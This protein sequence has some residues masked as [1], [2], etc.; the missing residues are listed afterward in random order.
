MSNKVY[1][2]GEIAN[3][4]GVKTS[5]LRFWENEFSQVRPKRTEKGQRYYSAKDLEILTQI[6]ELL[7][8]QGMTINGVQKAL[9]GI[10]TNEKANTSEKKQIHQYQLNFASLTIEKPK[11]QTE[12]TNY[13]A[14][15]DYQLKY[16]QLLLDLQNLQDDHKK[17]K[18]DFDKQNKYITEQETIIN[19]LENKNKELEN[20][21]KNNSISHQELKLQLLDILQ[22]L[23]SPDC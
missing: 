9:D 14:Q 18:N 16:E 19:N 8:N 10:Q 22:I 20:S 4:L 13:F 1:K 7:H 15:N 11:I 23:N 2:I 12:N 17:L 5:A 21:L 6:H 3:I